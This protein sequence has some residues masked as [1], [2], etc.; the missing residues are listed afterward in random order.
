MSNRRLVV[1]LLLLVSACFAADKSS[2]ARLKPAYRFE[3][4]KWIFVH[5][6]GSPADI[7]LVLIPS[8]RK[9]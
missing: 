1:S 2:D 4:S 7:G 3:R 6:E 8:T 9:S 5:L